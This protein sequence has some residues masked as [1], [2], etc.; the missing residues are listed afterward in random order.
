MHERGFADGRGWRCDEAS[1]VMEVHGLR[2]M[3]SG[4]HMHISVKQH[5]GLQPADHRAVDH[6]IAGFGHT[7]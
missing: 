3:L 2:P 1:V 5:S 4:G 6:W 7:Y